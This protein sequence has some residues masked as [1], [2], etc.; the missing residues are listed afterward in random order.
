MED[1]VLAKC[2]TYEALSAFIWRTRTQ[3]LRLQPHQ[4]T[5]F[6]LPVNGRSRLDPPLPERYFGS[7]VVYG[8]SLCSVDNLVKNSYS[9]AVGLIQDAIKMVTNDYIRSAIVY[10]EMTRAKLTSPT[11]IDLKIIS[12]TGLSF[13][14]TDFGWGRPVFASRASLPVQGVAHFISDM[15]EEEKE[16]NGINVLLGLPA[17]SMKNFQELLSPHLE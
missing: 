12:W 7:C 2:T 14:T 16:R 3:A 5:R 1:G 8:S 10:V 4:Q 17:S 11:L 6:S 9:F 15:K 13:H